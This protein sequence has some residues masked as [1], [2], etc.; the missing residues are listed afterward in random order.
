MLD[1]YIIRYCSPTLTGIKT[2]GLFTCPCEEP[3]ALK[4]E[5]CGIDGMLK[6][7]GIRIKL[8]RI[9]DKKAL[10]YAYRPSMLHKDLKNETAE[11]ILQERGYCTEKAGSGNCKKCLEHLIERLEE[12]KEFSHEIGLFLGY[13]PLDVSGFIEN[14]ACNYICKGCWKVYTDKEEA[15]RTFELYKKCTQEL[16]ADYR[17]G[18]S[19]MQLAKAV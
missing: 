2:A 17:R 19:L 14:K 11:C 3:D 15:V 12:Y 16:C 7:K 5:I 1:E 18:I 9:W 13:P 8:L 10:V 4:E 6:R